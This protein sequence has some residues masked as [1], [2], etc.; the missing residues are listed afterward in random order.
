[1]NFELTAEQLQLKE[2]S[3]DFAENKL[4][5]GVIE[6]DEA[7]EFPLELYR[8]F[9]E[10]GAYGLPYP[11]ALGGSGGT[12]MDYVLTVEEISKVDASFGI[13]YSV[14]TS[15]CGGS[16]MNSSAPDEFMI[17]PP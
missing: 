8:E 2:V 17:L 4:L 5:P 15:L 14:N 1:M 10:T 6:R 3:R 13:S 16:I 12:Y 11:E 7:S 9:G